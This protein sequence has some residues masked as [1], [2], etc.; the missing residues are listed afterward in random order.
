MNSSMSPNPSA[1]GTIE[2]T[3]ADF[4]WLARLQIQ[5]NGLQSL[6]AMWA[7]IIVRMFYIVRP[8]YDTSHGALSQAASLEDAQRDSLHIYGHCLSRG[9]RRSVHRTA[10]DRTA[11]KQDRHLRSFWIEGTATVGYCRCCQACLLRADGAAC[12]YTAA[13]FLRKRV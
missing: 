4:A 6:L 13:K 9:T 12:T 5:L 7:C 8:Y 11:N 2:A 3:K 1:G 10:S